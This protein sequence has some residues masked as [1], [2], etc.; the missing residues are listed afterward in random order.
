MTIPCVF[1]LTLKSTSTN[2]DSESAIDLS[3]AVAPSVVIG[4]L[5]I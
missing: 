3:I 4:L 5:P 1:E 2:E